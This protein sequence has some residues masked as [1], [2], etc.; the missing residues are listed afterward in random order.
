MFEKKDLE[1]K[2]QAWVDHRR[3]SGQWEAAPP[4]VGAGKAPRRKPYTPQ[5]SPLATVTVRRLAWALQL[6]M[7]KAVDRVVNV[8]PSLFSPSAVCP[9][10]KDRTKCGLCAFSQQSAAAPAVPAV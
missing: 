3:R 10:C 7:P 9:L 6:S 1:T 4:P 8:L 2:T 5:F